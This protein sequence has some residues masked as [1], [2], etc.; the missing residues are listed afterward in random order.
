M[1][2]L[3]RDAYGVLLPAFD[4][5]ELDE[6]VLGFLD[7]G[8]VSILLGESREEYVARSMSEHRRADETAEAFRNVVAQ[9]RARA[10]GSMLVAVDQEL[11]GICRLHDLSP[12]LPSAE[13]A[14]GMSEEAIATRSNATAMA[15]R[16]LGVNLFLAPI[17]DV[18]TGENPWIEGRHLGPEASESSRIA[19]AYIR[20][21]QAAGVAATAK[22]FPG[23]PVTPLD[24]AL[25][26]ATVSASMEELQ[27]SLSVFRDVIAEG[28]VA[29]MAG[30]ALVPAVDA[31]Q[32]ASTSRD[33]LSLL[34][35]ALGFTGLI[36][37]DD[38]DT[39]GIHRGRSIEQTAIASLAA[40]A[41]LLLLSS[42]AGLEQVARA[43]VAAVEDGTILPARL[44]E[45]AT[46]VRKLAVELDTLAQTD[47]ALSRKVH[48]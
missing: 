27:P 47:G 16:K 43:I 22:H 44:A 2:E 9:A 34:R 31:L 17:V 12:A 26:E 15:A 38:L 46:R 25:H 21:V 11:G 5:L 20:G 18:V 28:V 42:K 35:D 13:E 32:P 24:P 10:G 33:T 6:E 19:R 41:D 4:R 7:N 39:P 29:V 45:A 40:G 37:S 1:S 3:L 36:I 23:H 48:S 8:G 30:P 14:H